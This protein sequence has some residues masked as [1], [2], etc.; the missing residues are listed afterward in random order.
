MA[1]GCW[2]LETATRRTGTVE[3]ADLMVE[4]MEERFDGIAEVFGMDSV[5]ILRMVERT[6]L[7]R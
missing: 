7:M 2:Y 3:E 5:D 4:R 1:E 6:L